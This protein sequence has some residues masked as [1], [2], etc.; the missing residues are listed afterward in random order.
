MQKERKEYSMNDM[1]WDNAIST[2]AAKWA[3][4]PDE[5]SL[6]QSYPCPICHD[7][8]EIQIGRYQRSN[9]KMIGITIRCY[10]CDKA[11]AV[12]NVER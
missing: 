10:Q 11:I 8:L 2:F 4:N 9:T 5:F 12:D 1:I 7:R 6:E 3:K